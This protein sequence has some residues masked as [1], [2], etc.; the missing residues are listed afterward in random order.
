MN[1]NEH[2]LERPATL[3]LPAWPSDRLTLRAYCEVC[4][5]HRTFVTLAREFGGNGRTLKPGSLIPQ[6]DPMFAHYRH[7]LR[8]VNGE[9]FGASRCR[10]CR[11]PIVASWTV[12]DGRI[13][14]ARTLS[15]MQEN[16]DGVL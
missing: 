14:G 4:K 1:D 12:N 7:E 8:L 2:D 13:V 15:T 5:A 10:Q 16:V 3:R 9:I 6:A 11:Q